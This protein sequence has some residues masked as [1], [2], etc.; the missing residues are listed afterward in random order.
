MP[1]GIE[2][3][4]CRNVIKFEYFLLHLYYTS[5]LNDVYINDIFSIIYHLFAN[6]KSD[7][8][9]EMMQILL[10]GHNAVKMNKNLFMVLDLLNSLNLVA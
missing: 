4:N 9:I 1:P 2:K 10:Y 5:I 6:I 8:N 3:E 7:M